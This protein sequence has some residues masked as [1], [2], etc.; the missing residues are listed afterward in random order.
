MVT[1]I[2]CAKR[3]MIL[4]WSAFLTLFSYAVSSM[5]ILQ[6]FATKAANP[7][8]VGLAACL[9]I[10]I[11]LPGRAQSPT[12][13]YQRDIQPLF[14]RYCVA[15]LT[16]F[17]APCQLDLAHPDG[18]TR[19]ASRQPVY[20]GTRLEEAPPTRLFLDAKSNAA[21]A[22]RDACERIFSHRQPGCL[23]AQAERR[24]CGGDAKYLAPAERIGCADRGA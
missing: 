10:A 13:D 4:L 22:Q 20:D 3:L 14:D 2:D 5:R 17:D 6:R 9:L 7:R 8:V 15:C 12:I 19:G 16:C 24:A 23:A 11:P 21:R 1:A 18:L